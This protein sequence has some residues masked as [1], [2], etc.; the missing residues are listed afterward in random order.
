M[1]CCLDFRE[2]GILPMNPTP[3]SLWALAQRCQQHSS[4]YC[5]QEMG[6]APAAPTF[7]FYC[8]S[9]V[10]LELLN[11]SD[12]GERGASAGWGWKWV[13]SC[14]W[15][16]SVSNSSP[17]NKLDCQSHPWHSQRATSLM[18]WRGWQKLLLPKRYQWYLAQR[19]SVMLK[20]LVWQ[21]LGNPSSLV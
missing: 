3:R 20:Q 1:F 19:I 14:S 12:Q 4:K 8:W 7:H 17:W 2:R 13:E 9:Q 6:C 10:T 11:K 5:T 16:R 15:E 21:P 18:A